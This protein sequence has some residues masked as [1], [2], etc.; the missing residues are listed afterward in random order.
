MEATTDA[1]RW[2]PNKQL[3]KQQGLPPIV[4]TFRGIRSWSASRMP[5]TL[6]PIDLVH[7]VLNDGRDIIIGVLDPADLERELDASIVPRIEEVAS[8][9]TSI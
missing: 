3:Q 6:A 7:F 5:W 1:L 8:S 2:T 9:I 4:I